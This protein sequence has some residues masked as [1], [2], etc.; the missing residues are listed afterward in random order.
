MADRPPDDFLHEFLYDS[1]E[2]GVL[3][4]VLL[5]DERAEPAEA[6]EELAGFLSFR[7]NAEDY[8]IGIGEVYEIIR[9][10]P[11][12]EVPRSSKAILGLISLRGDALPIFDL[13]RLLGTEH[14]ATGVPPPAT[15][16]VVILQ[17]EKG[18]A[19]FLV[20]AVDQVLRLP[21]DSIEAP[22]RG[23]STS[24]AGA[25]LKGIGRW[26]GRLIAILD[27]VELM[28]PERRR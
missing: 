4:P 14:P 3:L 15:A 28:R 1:E 24:S 25:A 23:L 21:R 6:S 20:D 7:L 5:S 12:T 17:T 13:E 2:E 8:A 22:P 27:P 16:R 19:G 10:R 9:L 18:L 26:H 11:I